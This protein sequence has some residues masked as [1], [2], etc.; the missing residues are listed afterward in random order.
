[1]D[2]L[3]VHA[4]SY[5]HTT[6]VSANGSWEIVEIVMCIIYKHSSLP[7]HVH[8]PSWSLWQRETAV[9]QSLQRAPGLLSRVTQSSCNLNTIQF[10]TGFKCETRGVCHKDGLASV[11]SVA[12]PEFKVVGSCGKPNLRVL[13][14]LLTLFLRVSFLFK[15]KTLFNFL[16]DWVC[17]KAHSLLKVSCKSEGFFCPCIVILN[18]TML[19]SH[20]KKNTYFQSLYDDLTWYY[21]YIISLYKYANDT[22]L[23]I[24]LSPCFND[25]N[26]WLKGIKGNVCYC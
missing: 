5:I 26:N 20:R 17:I 6:N 10:N 8:R 24:S 22:L 3:H 21:H 12:E 16:I 2:I 4:G 15:L 18:F 23:Y 1:M 14:C 11:V 25:I 13:A 9:Q 19:H 7:Q